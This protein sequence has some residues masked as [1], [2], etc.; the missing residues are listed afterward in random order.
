M[1]ATVMSYAAIAMSKKEHHLGF[2]GVSVERPAMTE[3]DGFA[4]TPILIIDLSVI[5]SGEST[6]FNPPCFIFRKC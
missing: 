4:G 1:A 3:N 2:P 6:H 5:L